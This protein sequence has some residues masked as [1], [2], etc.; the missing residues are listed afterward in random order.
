[1]IARTNLF[2]FRIS[3]TE[4]QQ[5]SALADDEDVHAAALM[6]RWIKQRYEARFGEAPPKAKAKR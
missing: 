1:M 2:N 6:R 3:E 4:R 5:L